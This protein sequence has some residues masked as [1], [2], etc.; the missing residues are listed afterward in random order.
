MYKPGSRPDN[1][2]R[3]Q[4]DIIE[5]NLLQTGS[6]PLPKVAVTGLTQ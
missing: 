2:Q 1:L 5:D 3:V 6:K 4:T